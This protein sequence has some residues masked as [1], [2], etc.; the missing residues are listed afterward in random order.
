M[1]S[2]RRSPAAERRDEVDPVRHDE[3]RRRRR[4]RRAHVGREVGQRD[5]DLVADAAHERHRVRDDRPDDALVVERPQVLERS[6]TPGEDRDR[7]ARRPL[8]RRSPP[9]SI[10]RS[11]RRSA[12]TMLCGA[13]SPWTWH[14]TSST[15]ASG[16]RRASTLQTSRQTAPVGE[17]TTAI[18]RGRSGSGRLRAA[19]NRPSSDRR[20][21]SCSNR[22]ARLP[23][24]DGWSES[25]YSCS[26]PCGSN[27]SIRP[28]T[29]DLQP[30]LR[31][32]RRADPLVAEPH[33]LQLG[34]GVLQREVRVAGGRDRDP[35]DLALDPQVPQ[36]VVGPHALADRP[37][38]LGHGLDVEPEG[39]AGDGG[40]LR[41]TGASIAGMVPTSGRASRA[42][43]RRSS[44]EP[45]LH[46]AASGR[47]AESW[48]R[49]WLISPAW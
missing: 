17:V 47:R 29:I 5:V 13:P 48:L 34:S 18:T 26:A 49:R 37:A 43:P 22:I 2:S 24:P 16:Q 6:P 46:V 12:P 36:P 31:L 3:L 23:N 10:Q 19:S 11:R 21:F 7:R 8:G 35:P 14:A 41:S 45:E 33:A 28:W 25:T 9:R 20:A 44:A 32:E 42:A 1:A 4:G 40:P 15:R 38:D 30:G 27:T 39:A